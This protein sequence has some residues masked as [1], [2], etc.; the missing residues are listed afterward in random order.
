RA[1]AQ[2]SHARVEAARATLTRTVLRAPFN[3][4]IAKLTGELGEFSTPSPPGIPT[5]PVIDL[6]DDSCLYVTAPIDEVDVANV[7]VGQPAYITIQALPDRRFSGR[8]RRVAP[9]VLDVEKQARTVDVEVEF[10]DRADSKALLV[11]YSADAEIILDARNDALRIPTQALLEGNRVLV[12]GE[13]PG[14]LEERQVTTG[15]S[16]WKYSE[17]RSGLRK[18]DRVVLSIER[19]G[20]VAGARAIPEKQ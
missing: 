16:N 10:A 3:G 6:I 7:R 20:V 4:V 14:I 9:Y 2:Q 15:L 5:P 18:G 13:N 19:K 17:V 1:D 8:V 12:Y 11:G